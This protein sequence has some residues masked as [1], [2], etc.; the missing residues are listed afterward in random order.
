MTPPNR[1]IRF[2]RIRLSICDP[3]FH[4]VSEIGQW[5]YYRPNSEQEFPAVNP[6]GIIE[7]STNSIFFANSEKGH[8]IEGFDKSGKLKRIIRKDFIPVPLAGRFKEARP[9]IMTYEESGVESNYWHDILNQQGRFVGRVIVDNYGTYGKSQG[10]L[11]TL[12]RTG[13]LYHFRENRD[14]FKELAVCTI[15]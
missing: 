3:D 1:R 11:F 8:E 6:T 2:N 15:K 5:K 12:A 10:F 13:R 7:V 9:F 14:G 4:I